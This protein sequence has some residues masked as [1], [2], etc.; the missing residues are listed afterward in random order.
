MVKTS[1]ALFI[2][3]VYTNINLNHLLRQVNVIVMNV[4]IVQQENVSMSVLKTSTTRP[5]NVKI[6]LIL[7]QMDVFDQQT[8]ATAYRPT[9]LPVLYLMRVKHV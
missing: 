9:V 6:V 7:A 2:E 5:L 3:F 8:A 1:L 4:L